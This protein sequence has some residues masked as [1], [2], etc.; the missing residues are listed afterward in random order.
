MPKGGNRSGFQYSFC[1]YSTHRKCLC[2]AG[3][4]VSIQLLFLFN[5]NL[6][7]GYCH[8]PVSIQLLFLFNV[9]QVYAVC[10]ENVCFNTASVLI[11]PMIVR[12]VLRNGLFQYSFCSYSTIICSSSINFSFQYSFCSYS[13]KKNQENK[14]DTSK[15]QYS[16]CSYS[17]KFLKSYLGR[18]LVSIQLLFLFN[19]L[20]MGM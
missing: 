5:L 20:G 10:V 2:L 4:I 14:S 16:F 11:Q 1:S 9:F 13:T 12:C 3:R 8:L 7:L 6:I 18:L 15:F 17:T 19:R